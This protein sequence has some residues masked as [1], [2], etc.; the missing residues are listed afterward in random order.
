ME[1]VA[2]SEGAIPS[3]K[4]HFITCKM[5]NPSNYDNKVKFFMYFPASDVT[6]MRT[7][8]PQPPTTL[9]LSAIAI[10]TS[11]NDIHS[12]LTPVEGNLNSLSWILDFNPCFIYYHSPKNS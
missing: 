3:K 9:D 2:F 8:P 4:F 6:E 7:P 1:L 12:P 10:E 11:I 5:I